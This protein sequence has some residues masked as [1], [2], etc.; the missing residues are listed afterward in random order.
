MILRG[1]PIV[2]V[3]LFLSFGFGSI[4]V[5]PKTLNF[6][7]RKCFRFKGS[8]TTPF[9]LTIES[10]LLSIPTWRPYFYEEFANLNRRLFLLKLDLLAVS[11][12]YLFTT[13]SSSYSRS[14]VPTWISTELFF[15]LC[16]NLFSWIDFFNFEADS[17]AISSFFIFISLIVRIYA[18][19]SEQELWA[20]SLFSFIFNNYFLTSF[21]KMLSFNDF[22]YFWTSRK[23]FAVA[24]I[25]FFPKSLSDS[26]V[27][28]V[29][30]P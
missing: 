7:I 18:S 30:F 1:S 2:C 3:S 20:S 13:C 29:F 16:S 4:K 22:S 5:S 9:S 24:K 28:W 11:T 10:S 6:C 15:L 19:L 14:S 8:D 26:I 25:K 17:S 27:K 23:V 12:F 21:K